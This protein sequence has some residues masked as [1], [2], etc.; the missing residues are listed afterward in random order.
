MSRR[1][2]ASPRDR[3]KSRRRRRSGPLVAARGIARAGAALA[4]AGNAAG[5][6]REALI[7]RGV[8]GVRSS[9]RSSM[10][11]EPTRERESGEKVNKK[12]ASSKRKEKKKSNS[13]SLREAL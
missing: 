13:T 1:R 8:R 11:Q 7:V 4:E 3:Q 9:R 12:K 6:K 2:A 5:R 10:P